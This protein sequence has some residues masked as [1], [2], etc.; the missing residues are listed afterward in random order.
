MPST[1]SPTPCPSRRIGGTRA[2]WSAWSCASSRGP[3]ASAS[4][5]TSPSSTTSASPASSLRRGGWRRLLA[6]GRGTVWRCWPPTT[7]WR[8]RSEQDRMKEPTPRER[9]HWA[10]RRWARALRGRRGRPLGLLVLAG[11]LLLVVFPE[12]P[13]FRQVRLASFDAYQSVVPR[14]PRSA[15]VVIVAIDEESLLRLGQWP[16]PR[17]SL[18]ALVNRVAAAQPVA[19]GVDILMPEPDRL[20]PHRLADMIEG[21]PPELARALRSMPSN[22]TVLADALRGRRVVL[23]VAGVDADEA[24]RPV[25]LGP[26]PIRTFGGDPARF[27]PHFP[28]ALASIE[29]I[30]LAVAGRGVVRRLPLLATVGD[31]LMPAL[32]L[33]MLRVAADAPA[34]AVSVGMDRIR[35][36]AVGDLVVPTERDGR[37]WL[38]YSRREPGRFVSAAEVLAGR[39]DPERLKDRFVLVGVT[40]AGLADLHAT[41][42][43]DRQ[44]SVEIHAQFLEDVVDRSLLW[45][46][47]L[48]RWIETA[49]LAVAGLLIVFL[50]PRLRARRAALLVLVLIAAFV[51][52]GA[53]LYLTR[54]ILMD[55]ATASLALAVLFTVM[56]AVTLADAE[57]QRRALRRQVE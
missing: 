26:P 17:T 31:T 33:E 11:L 29:E 41:P 55:A 23:G 38:H 40:A 49:A 15:P 8:S 39:I 22:D 6:R 10:E 32:G 50:V 13:G 54:S 14:V 52:V 16:W 20:S 48:A 5:T 19:I 28:A 25:A 18:A 35:A 3:A 9:A 1:P 24:G 51:V 4:I 2:T 56:L 53:M 21:M 43:G 27:V 42:L 7:A 37:V 12:V 30:S 57:T 46:P 36:V 47:A 34:L 44:S 45:R